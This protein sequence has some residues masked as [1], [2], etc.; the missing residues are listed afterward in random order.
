MKQALEALGP[1]MTV[2]QCAEWI[3]KHRDD[4]R[5]RMVEESTELTA[6]QVIERVRRLVDGGAYADLMARIE[7]VETEGAARAA[8][9]DLERQHERSGARNAISTLEARL[10]EQ[11]AACAEADARVAEAERKA[12]EMTERWKALRDLVAE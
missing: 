3:V 4:T 9:A 5:E 10:E 12:R 7:A 11:R 1:E 6:D 8:Q 2:E